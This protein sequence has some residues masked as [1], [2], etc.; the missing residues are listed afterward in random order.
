MNGRNVKLI[1]G[2]LGGMQYEPMIS[3]CVAFQS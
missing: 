3:C 2:N 1:P